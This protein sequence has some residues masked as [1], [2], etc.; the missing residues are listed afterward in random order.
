ME[1]EKPSS[2]VDCSFSGVVDESAS[3]VDGGFVV[4]SVDTVD[5]FS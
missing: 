5:V 1:E 2:E 4:E 3:V